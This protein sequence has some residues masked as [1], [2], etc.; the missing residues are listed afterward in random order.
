M[1]LNLAKGKEELK[2]LITKERK[3]KT[4]KPVGI[5]KIGRRFRGPSSELKTVIFHQMKMT[6]TMKMVRV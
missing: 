4:R 1:F 5:L 6:T 3:K 2:T